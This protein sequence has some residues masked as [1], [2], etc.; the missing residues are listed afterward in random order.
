MFKNYKKDNMKITSLEELKNWNHNPTEEIPVVMEWYMDWIFD[1]VLEKVDFYLFVDAFDTFVEFTAKAEK[2]TLNKA[3]KK[4]IENLCY[5]GD[6][7]NKE[8]E[9]FMLFIDGVR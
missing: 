5:W 6:R 2:I 7:A 4:V 8:S 1:E 9:P 3:K